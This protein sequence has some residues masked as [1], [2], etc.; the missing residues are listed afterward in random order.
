VGS[1]YIRSLHPYLYRLGI[2]FRRFPSLRA[3]GRK[4]SHP[5][6]VTDTHIHTH[7]S[8]SSSLSSASLSQTPQPQ[9]KIFHYTPTPSTARTSPFQTSIALLQFFLGAWLWVSGQQIGSLACTGL[10][11]WVVFDAIG[12]WIAG[13]MGGLIGR[14]LGGETAEG[15]KDKKGG[16]VRRPFGYVVRSFFPLDL[17]SPLLCLSAYAQ[18]INC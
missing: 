18:I 14:R 9:T 1:N 17:S 3:K 12:I 4:V 15:G 2:L 11:Y 10:G 7:S 5:G 8:L 13:G 6:T 16:S